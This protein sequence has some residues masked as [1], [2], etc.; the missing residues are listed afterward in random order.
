MSASSGTDRSPALIH[1]VIARL[2]VGGPAMHVVNL[3]SAMNRG[4]WRTRLLAGSVMETEGD[5]E[6]YAGERGVEVTHIRGLSREISPMADLGTL[7]ALY[8]WFRRERPA[9]VHTHT[10]KAGTLGRLAAILAGVPVRIHTFHGHVLGGG[11]FSPARTRF[12]LAVERWLARATQRLVVLT[13]AQAQEMAE[14]LRVAPREKFAVV[15]LGLELRRFAERDREAVR[16][17]T[18]AR[19]G[20]ADGVKVVGMVGRMVPIKN[21]ELFLEAMALTDPEI[22]AMVVG[23]GERASYLKEY[24]DARGVGD[25]IRW[26]GWRSDLEDLYPAMDVVALTSHDEGTPVALLEAMAAGCRVAAR[27]VGG[28]GEVLA[29]VE[30]PTGA[31]P[32]A[33]LPRSSGAEAWARAL[34]EEAGREPLE[35]RVREYVAR[36][37]SVERLARD[38]DALYRSAGVKAPPPAD[39]VG[40]GPGEGSRVPQND[41][42][43]E[44]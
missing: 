10:A 18:R 41:E 34:E 24:A 37:F 42:R 28:V 31:P 16:R 20:I 35:S 1:R 3:T 38:M 26:L 12:F 22:E 33:L 21:H 43:R 9:V 25:R 40:G 27:D 14:D 4:P 17:E 32:G 5:M 30:K 13:R 11:Y 39:G 19:L 29:E 2:N 23:S 15:P 8:R 6:Y 36:S 7:W 44:T